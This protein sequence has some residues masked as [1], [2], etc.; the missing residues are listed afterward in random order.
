MFDG[1]IISSD[2]P[3]MVSRVFDQAYGQCYLIDTTSLQQTSPAEGSILLGETKENWFW[4]GIYW[5]RKAIFNF[6]TLMVMYVGL[7]IMVNTHRLTGWL[8]Y[9]NS[10]DGITVN[11]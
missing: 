5:I 11:F 8:S 2:I 6:H 1:E 10:L 4:S 9:P 3:T 7:Q